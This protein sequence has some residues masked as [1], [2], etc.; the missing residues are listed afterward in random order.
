MSTTRYNV[1][2]SESHSAIEHTQEYTLPELMRMRV[3]WWIG[4]RPAY[5][6][7]LDWDAK[8]Q[9]ILQPKVKGDGHGNRYTIEGKSI[10]K[11]FRVYGPGI[12][13]LKKHDKNSRANKNNH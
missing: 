11:F 9:N 4:S 13:L 10:I 12:N 3:F 6:K 1:D 7:L 2:M 8:E 5:M